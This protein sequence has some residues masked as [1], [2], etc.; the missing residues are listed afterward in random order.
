MSLGLF[1]TLKIG[2]ATQTRKFWVNYFHLILGTPDT[3]LGVDAIQLGLGQALFRLVHR[4]LAGV[5]EAIP[6]IVV[7]E[8]WFTH[9]PVDSGL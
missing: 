8:L 4:T 2:I 6:P 5:M 7:L 9:D 1:D 3:A